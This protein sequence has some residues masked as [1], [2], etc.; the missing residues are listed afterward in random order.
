MDHDRI[1]K[2]LLIG[3][4]IVRNLGG[5]SLLPTTMQVLNR[6]FDNVEYTFIS[7]TREDLSLAPTYGLKMIPIPKMWKILLPAILRK[8]T[9]ISVGPANIRQATSAFASADLVIQTWGIW[10]A[11]SLGSNKI[12]TR[13]NHSIYFFVAKIF[14]K[15]FVKYTADLGPFELRWNRFFAKLCLQNATDLILARNEITKNRLLNLGITTPIHVCPDTGFLL[16]PKSTPFSEQLGRI[17]E[18][19]PLI[20]MSVSYQAA[21]QSGD[22]EKYI[23]NMAKVADHIINT[24]GAVI[25]FIPN[26][27]SKD[28]SSD[29][30]VFVEDTIKRMVNNANVLRVEPELT[31]SELKGVIGQC[32]LNVASRYHTI[33]ASLSQKVPVVVV[34]WH[35]KYLGL[36][37][38][39]GQE[40][41]LVNVRSFSSDE[42]AAKFDHL[43]KYKDQKRLEIE[44]ALPDIIKAI[45]MGGEITKNVYLEKV[46]RKEPS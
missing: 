45:Y 11:D 35:E 37:K 32:D 2:I 26:E 15:P 29:D 21:S 7:P 8:F 13:F 43:W 23:G 46:G 3:P 41:Y 33:V 42:L 5:P 6:A 36:L 40:E 1:I 27:L 20:G 38:L 22:A 39:A 18:K 9:G 19:Q 17:R 4:R 31:A 12:S 14:R 28:A 25:L 10:F 34:G 16:E 44:N 30:R 24:L